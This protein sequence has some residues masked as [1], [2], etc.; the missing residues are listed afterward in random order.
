MADAF[1]AAR[2]GPDVEPRCH[3]CGSMLARL[4]S[5]PWVIDCRRCRAR[6]AMGATQAQLDELSRRSHPA[7]RHPGRRLVP[8]S[9]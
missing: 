2:G 8:V 6:N 3:R 4:V 1:G 7:G 5:R 9:S